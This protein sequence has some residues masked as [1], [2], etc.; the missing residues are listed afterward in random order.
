MNSPPVPAGGT[1]GGPSLVFLGT[2]DFAVPGLDLLVQAGF[3]P[4]VVVTAPDRPRGRGLHPRPVPVKLAALR[5]GLPVLQPESLREP[6]FLSSVRELRPDIMVV[7]AFRILPVEVYSM[8]R[9]GSFNLHASLLPRYR[10]AAPIQW[11]LINGERETGVTT[12]LL[13][14]KVDTGAVLLQARTDIAPEE[15]AGSL[16]DRLSLLGARLVVETVGMLLGGKAAPLP[17]DDAQATPAPRIFREDCRLRWDAPAARLH[18]R[19]RGL[20]P[21]PGAFSLLEGGLVKLFRSRVTELPPFGAPG[22]LRVEED[23]LEVACSDR[24]LEI[25][26][27]QQEGRKRMTAPRFIRGARL[28]PGL[29]FS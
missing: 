19:I 25:Q 11:A 4:S 10:G 18:D 22:A 5:H 29:R 16:H 14:E 21:A 23:M 3:R 7:A 2:P 12:F 1:S 27:L 20:A 6:A 8:A 13:Q 26:E 15:D 28:G 9:L 17:Q 24:V